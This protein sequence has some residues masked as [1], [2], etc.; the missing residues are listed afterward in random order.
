MEV[1]NCHLL[2]SL[3][4]LIL[5]LAEQRRGKTVFF[6]SL[7]ILFSKVMRGRWGLIF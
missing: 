6:N 1:G 2:L 5:V 4:N 3:L 7:D